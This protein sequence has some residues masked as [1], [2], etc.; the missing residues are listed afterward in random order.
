MEVEEE[1]KKLL[2]INT[3]QG[4]FQ[5]NRLVFGVA[6]APAIWQRTI[7]QVL[8]G[9]PGTK[10]IL[11]DMVITRK[12]DEEHLRNLEMV[13]K[14]LHEYGLKAN[15]KKC[16]FFQDKIQFC[17]H[18]IDK[19]GL[20]KTQEK[21]S[22]VVQAPRPMSVT[23]VWSF[24]GLVNYYSHFLPR[25]STLVRPLNQ[26][27]EKHHKWKWTESCE[28]AFQKA[29]KLV[30]SDQVLTHYDP[31]LPRRM[32]S[33]ASPYGLGA[34]LSHVTK[35]GSE[36]PIAF[37][38]RSV[39]K[40]EQKYAQIDKEALALIWGIKKFHQYLFGRRFTI[41]TDHQP[42]THIFHPHNS[43]QTTTAA[44]LQRYA[45]LLSGFEY[46][47]V[48]KATAHHGN[49]DCLSRLPLNNERD[50]VNDSEAADPVH[51]FHVAQLESLPVTSIM[52]RQATSRDPVLSKVFES[53]LKGWQ[54]FSSPI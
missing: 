46:D 2:T 45:L 17:A 42:L 36:R 35:D 13:L 39:T 4:L 34:V 31:D 18:E 12:T 30:S 53:I 19:N 15:T 10:C 24:L 26:L 5:Y 41:L 27:L 29:K 33:D 25:L 16:E 48:Y 7:E 8:G 6:S 32:A 43:I 50:D 1:S 47:I 40:T 20:H 52:V 37:A 28:Q 23:Q 3:S 54:N 44:R 11:D 22:A 51:V 14:R 21:I 9:I 49:A 38:S